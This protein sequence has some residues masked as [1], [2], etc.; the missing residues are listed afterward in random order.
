[1]S[2]DGDNWG[3]ASGTWIG[4]D[5]SHAYILAAAHT[6]DMPPAPDTYLVRAASGK[7]LKPDRAWSHPDWNGD[8]DTRTGWDLTIL[9]IPGPLTDMGEA[10]WLYNGDD[11]HGRLITFV[12]F[13]SRGIGS[14]GQQDRFYEGSD[15]AAA[16]GMVDQWVG[17]EKRLKEDEDGGNYLGIY[18][19]HEDGSIENPYDGAT[20]PTTP[21][22]GLL[23]SGD[24][25]GSAWL[26]IGAKWVIVAVN[27]NGD[28]N[29][30]Y[31][32]SSWFTRIQPHER[33][34]RGIFPGARFTS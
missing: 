8:T 20:K 18:L 30:N 27:S 6:F 12:G 29:A 5:A 32:D 15:K 23:G 7:I 2:Y 11:E 21:L 10:P 25:G 34:I 31:G 9:R 26:Q 4:N 28:G 14:V 1:M 22:V 19:P 33:W 17:P 16:Q 13:G 24:S 3:E